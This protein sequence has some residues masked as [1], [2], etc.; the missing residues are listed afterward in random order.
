MVRR[1]YNLLRNVSL[2]LTYL[3]A[4]RRME[5]APCCSRE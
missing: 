1:A 5:L 3:S 4:S 2:D